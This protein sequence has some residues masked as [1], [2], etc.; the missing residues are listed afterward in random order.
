MIKKVVGILIVGLLMATI[1]P[2]GSSIAETIDEK[3]INKLSSSQIE[4]TIKGGFAIHAFIKNIGTTDLN[5]ADMTIVLDGR[6]IFPAYKNREATT[7]IEAGKT[8]LHIIPV[9][10]FGATNIEITVD[11][12]TETASATVLGRIVFGVQ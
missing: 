12:T 11:S 4:I 7:C 9:F 5:D 6:L 1:L 8:V 10:G 3:D 2:V